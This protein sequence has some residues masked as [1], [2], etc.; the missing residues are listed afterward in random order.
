MA[1]IEVR[2]VTVQYRGRAAMDEV[3][4][5]VAEGEI[6][7]LLGRNGAGKTTTVKMIAGLGRPDSGSVRVR[8]LD[9]HRDRAAVRGVLGVQLQSAALHGS[10]T[11]DELVRL[12]SSFHS[13]PAD[14]VALLEAV[15]LTDHRRVRFENLSGGQQQRLSIVLA[16]IGAPRVVLLDELTTGLDPDARRTV[17]A[18][19]AGLKADGVSILLVSHQMDE[20]H[21]LCD[22]VTVLDHGRVIAEGTPQSLIDRSGLS[23]DA[24]PT[25]EDAFLALTNGARS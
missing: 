19:I 6:H 20:V 3:D 16:L 9:P 17:W 18:L 7:G 15:E 22:R 5:T 2:G 13:R 23:E 10:L 8:S 11:V 4:L 14:G 1:A 21:R 24:R 12:F 25:L